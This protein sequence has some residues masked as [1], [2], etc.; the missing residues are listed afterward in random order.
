MIRNWNKLYKRFGIGT[1]GITDTSQCYCSFV[2]WSMCKHYVFVG[3][4]EWAPRNI[5]LTGAS[6]VIISV[7][8]IFNFIEWATRLLLLY[9]S[10]NRLTVQA[11]WVGAKAARQQNATPVR[12]AFCAVGRK[13]CT[14]NTTNGI[15]HLGT[16]YSQF[17]DIINSIVIKAANETNQPSHAHRA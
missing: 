10:M 8:Y 13:Q 3:C 15:Y 1:I 6:H 5:Q 4:G 9:I 14:F 2:Q 12:R 11:T 7:W 16:N 17:S